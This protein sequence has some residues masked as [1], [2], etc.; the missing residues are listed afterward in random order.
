VTSS[1]ALS[2]L[3][4]EGL[5]AQSHGR[6]WQFKPTLEGDSALRDSYVFRIAVEPTSFGMPTFV[7]DPASLNR[8]YERHGHFRVGINLHSADSKSFFDFDA[9]FHETLASFSGNSFMIHAI[10][11]QNR[12]RRLFEFQ[13]YADAPR[14]KTWIMEHLE[15]MAGIMRDSQTPQAC[16]GTTIS[17]PQVRMRP[18]T[19]ICGLRD[20][21]NAIAR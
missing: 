3:A 21:E 14:V 19:G 13:T 11:H 2:R 7:V 20:V 1:C 16:P 18:R 9:E 6:G 10:Q 8:M 12:L 17:P 5:I 4:D 15:I